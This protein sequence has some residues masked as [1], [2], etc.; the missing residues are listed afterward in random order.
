MNKALLA[1]IIFS[2]LFPTLGWSHGSHGSGFVA[3][4]T[5]PIFGL[6]HAFAIFGLGIM[7]HYLKP[8]SWYFYPLA[9][10]APMVVAGYIGI[11]QEGIVFVEK[12]IALSVVVIGLG[13]ALLKPKSNLAIYLAIAL[14]GAFHGFA[15][16]TEMPEGTTALQYIPG[17]LVGALLLSIVGLAVGKMIDR[18]VN[19]L[20][21]YVLLGGFIAGAGFIILIS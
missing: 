20:R 18:T 7:S 16:G 5:H 21:Y 9:F 19:S 12:I 1:L 4:L 11:D 2:I 6:D 13:L 17:F 3:G 15:H 8:T 10:I 14:F